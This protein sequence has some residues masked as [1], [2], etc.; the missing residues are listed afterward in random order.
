MSIWT[1]RMT[2]W[3][4][5]T[6]SRRR[7]IGRAHA[8]CICRQITLSSRSSVPTRPASRQSLDM[9]SVQTSFIRTQV[10][11]VKREVFR[12]VVIKISIMTSGRTWL[13]CRYGRKGEKKLS[14]Q[15]QHLTRN[16]KLI[17]IVV[18]VI[19]KA[20]WRNNL[21]PHQSWTLRDSLFAFLVRFLVNISSQQ[22]ER[23]LFQMGF[24]MSLQLRSVRTSFCL[25]WSATLEKSFLW[26]LK[27][28]IKL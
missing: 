2:C 27:L 17:F 5:T 10:S 12:R 1:S 9:C 13:H 7:Q 6:R 14:F 22:P 20:S 3:I 8:C 4:C 25:S 11:E 19:N 23:D 18:F 28:Q 26:R 21:V 15:F 16:I 24:S